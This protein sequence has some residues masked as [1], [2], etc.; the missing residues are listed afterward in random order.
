MPG[1][2]S[3]DPHLFMRDLEHFFG[4]R[5]NDQTLCIQKVF[6]GCPGHISGN[7]AYALALLWA[8]IEGTDDD[9]AL[10]ELCDLYNELAGRNKQAARE[11]QATALGTVRR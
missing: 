8:M 7:P 2:C 5:L 1:E 6:Y 9:L 3:P 10:S 11:Q 4:L